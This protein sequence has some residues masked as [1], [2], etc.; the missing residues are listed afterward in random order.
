MSKRTFIITVTLDPEPFG[1]ES[2]ED[3]QETADE[4]LEAMREDILDTDYYGAEASVMWVGGQAKPKEQFMKEAADATRI[5][6]RT[7]NER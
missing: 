4:L 7:S 2:N 5:K 3:M 6:W 1:I